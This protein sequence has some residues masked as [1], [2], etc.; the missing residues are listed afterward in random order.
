MICIPKTRRKHNVVGLLSHTNA[1]ATQQDDS[2]WATALAMSYYIN[3]I[4][5]NSLVI[6]VQWTA[7]HTRYLKKLAKSFEIRSMAQSSCCHISSQV[8]DACLSFVQLSATKQDKTLK[9]ER[10]WKVTVVTSDVSL[11]VN[12]CKKKFWSYLSKACGCFSEISSSSWLLQFL[13]LPFCSV[14]VIWMDVARSLSLAKHQNHRSH[15]IVHE[16]LFTLW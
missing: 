6:R 3:M 15:S 5:T 12:I 16:I 4:P 10:L 9:Y 2:Y 14:A 13:S 11:R 1:W 7:V 8:A